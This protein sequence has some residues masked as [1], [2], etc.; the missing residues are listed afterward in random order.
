MGDRA[1]TAQS[2]PTPPPGSIS[3]YD[4]DHT[5]Y[6]ISPRGIAAIRSPYPN[7]IR[8]GAQSS[9]SRNNDAL[10]P[11]VE[12]NEKR[13]SKK[14]VLST[15]KGGHT[16]NEAQ[17][18]TSQGGHAPN[19]AQGSEGAQVLSE[20]DG[21]EIE[22]E[23]EEEF[24][25][26]NQVHMPTVLRPKPATRFSRT[27]PLDDDDLED[28]PPRRPSRRPSRP[29][30]TPT[31]KATPP[32]AP[33]RRSQSAPKSNKRRRESKTPG[34]RASED[35]DT[36]LVSRQAA[37][38]R[39]PA[40]IITLSPSVDPTKTTSRKASKAHETTKKHRPTP[41]TTRT[42]SSAVLSRAKSAASGRA[43]QSKFVSLETD[44]EL[45]ADQPSAVKME[46]MPAEPPAGI[47]EDPLLSAQ[48]LSKT[49]LLVSASNMTHKAPIMIPLSQCRSFNHLFDIL[50][51]ERGLKPEVARKVEDLSATYPWATRGHCIRKE[52]PE[53]WERFLTD[54]QKAWDNE[55]G[56]FKKD[57]DG[58]CK[59]EVMIHVD[60]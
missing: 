12:P 8:R 44:S 42:P 33:L 47:E 55:G 58:E 19:E 17:V 36:P 49:I 56:K 40:R 28:Q 21:H 51:T 60:E 4:R 53:H 37:K 9:T 11:S 22:D 29:Q 46:E 45:E 31:P 50:T 26:F 43:Q 59:V 27:A 35:S 34:N 57:E 23:S 5:N 24:N 20:G 32:S 41:T 1:G 16:P 6:D 15:S 48:A 13:G 2:T 30:A 18:S 14:H 54:V 3:R 7:E 10:Q 52:R 38:K 25:V 39:T